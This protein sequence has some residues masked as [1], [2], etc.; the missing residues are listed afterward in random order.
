MGAKRRS[1][2]LTMSPPPVFATVHP[3]PPTKVNY[4]AIGHDTGPFRQKKSIVIV[5]ES[6]LLGGHQLGRDTK[7]FQGG[8]RGTQLQQTWGPL[9]KGAIVYFIFKQKFYR[10]GLPSSIVIR[11]YEIGFFLIYSFLKNNCLNFRYNREQGITE[12]R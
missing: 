8:G 10:N 12:A 4:L 1:P 3:H 7:F 2:S 6:N 11:L 9:S 5:L